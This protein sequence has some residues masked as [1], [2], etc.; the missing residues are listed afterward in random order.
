MESPSASMDWSN[1]KFVE[2]NVRTGLDK[3]LLISM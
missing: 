1:G 3:K 2:G